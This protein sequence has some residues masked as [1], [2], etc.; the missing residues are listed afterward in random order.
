SL[1]PIPGLIHQAASVSEKQ[2]QKDVANALPKHSYW[3]DFWLFL[4]FD[5]VLFLIVYLLV[6]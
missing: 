4:L 1:V 3:F 5:V 2:R 6:P